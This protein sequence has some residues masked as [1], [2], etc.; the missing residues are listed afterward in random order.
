MKLFAVLLFFTSLSPAVHAQ[1]GTGRGGH[2]PLTILKYLRTLN[3]E[4]SECQLLMKFKNK[5]LQQGSYFDWD[6]PQVKA[7]LDSCSRHL[8]KQ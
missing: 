2:D 4:L 3:P 6:D 8:E 1:E 7:F 5:D